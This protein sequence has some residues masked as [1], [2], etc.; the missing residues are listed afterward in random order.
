MN[1]RNGNVLLR[2]LRSLLAKERPCTHLFFLGDIFD[3]W[4]GD[5]VYFAD[6][7]RPF[8]EALT[9]LVRQG[10][11][12]YY[13]EGNHDVHVKEFWQRLGVVSFVED[14]TF[15]VGPW[16][17]RVSHGDLMNPQDRAYAR[18][19]NFIRLPAL[20]KLAH[21]L[22]AKQ[23]HAFGKWASQNSRKKSGVRRR[24]NEPIL[25]TMIHDYARKVYTEVP[26]DFL[27]SGHMHIQ[28]EWPLFEG[29]P[30]PISIN[31][32]SWFDQPTVLWVDDHNYG[33]E[34]LQS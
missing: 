20:E 13:V 7:F 9:T 30:M 8:V 29:R 15:T 1:E 4:I 24:T 19:R 32:G 14:R 26:F 33:W 18:Y 23:L 21:Q 27:I 25:R 5:H 16:R 31:L 17:I 11:S 28:D 10:V 22:P 3:L 2:F 34:Q 12:V 6:S